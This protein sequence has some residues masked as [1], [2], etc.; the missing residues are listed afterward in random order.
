MIPETT[1][2]I[3]TC[4]GC[5][6]RRPVADLRRLSLDAAGQLHVDRRGAGRGAWL[7]AETAASCFTVA[8]ERRALLR[9]LRA[10]PA[11]SS[12]DAVALR[13]ATEQGSG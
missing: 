10:E 6:T 1:G 5:R 9:A 4:I 2:P 7:C 11:P 13:L 12:V 8:T 3:R